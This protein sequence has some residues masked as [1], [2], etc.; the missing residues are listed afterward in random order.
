MSRAHLSVHQLQGTRNLVLYCGHC[1]GALHLALPIAAT[2]T[3][4]AIERFSERH[5]RCKAEEKPA[6]PF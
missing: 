2:E 5:E 3:L 1:T 6:G 4:A